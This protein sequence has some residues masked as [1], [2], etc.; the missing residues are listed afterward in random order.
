MA[1]SPPTHCLLQGTRDFR[2]VEVELNSYWFLDDDIEDDDDDPWPELWYNVLH[3]LESLWWVAAHFIIARAV[4][5]RDNEEWTE[6][7]RRYCELHGRLANEI[8]Y[9]KGKRESV[10]TNQNFLAARIRMLHPAL[11]EVGKKL[12]ESRRE[13]VRAHSK[14]EKVVRKIDCHSADGVHEMLH[15]CFAFIAERFSEN[16]LRMEPI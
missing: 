2:A 7:G 10:M 12:L 14:A 4:T 9:T 11:R 8:F 13:L 6:E 3:D 16:D 15:D 1:T 5:P